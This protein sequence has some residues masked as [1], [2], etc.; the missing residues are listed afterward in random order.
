MSDTVLN[1]TLKA[2]ME[3]GGPDTQQMSAVLGA[4]FNQT[5]ENPHWMFYKANLSAPFK[6]AE[7]RMAKEGDK[8]LLNIDF[9]EDTTITRSSLDLTPWGKLAGIDPNP[10]I[11][12]EGADSYIYEVGKVRIAFQFTHSSE[13]LLLVA[14]EWGG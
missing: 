2:V 8:A 12:P 3:L 10:R 1:D 9:P 11:P 14:V 7:L 5:N 13:R 6:S 4:T